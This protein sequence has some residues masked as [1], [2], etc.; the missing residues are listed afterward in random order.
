VLKRPKINVKVIL[1]FFKFLI[2]IIDL[3]KTTNK[4]KNLLKK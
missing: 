1:K 2:F 3:V 4:N